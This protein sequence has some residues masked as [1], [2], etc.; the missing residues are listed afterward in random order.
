FMV[1]RTS[2][3]QANTMTENDTDRMS[4]ITTT[5]ILSSTPTETA[6]ISAVLPSDDNSN[7]QDN[8]TNWKVNDVY[9]DGPDGGYGWWVILGAFLG[10]FTSFGTASSCFAGTIME[11]FVDLMG[12]VFQIVAARYGVRTVLILGSFL[13]VLGLELAGF[14]TKVTIIIY[15]ICISHKVFYS[16]QVHLL[17]MCIVIN[18]CSSNIDV[19]CLKKAAMSVPAQWFNRRRGVGLGIVSSGSGFG[20]LILPFIMTGINDKLGAS[21]TYRIM[22]FVCL[23]MNVVT[24]LL[25]KEKYPRHKKQKVNTGNKE[26]GEE[27]QQ[28]SESRHPTL[29]ETFNFSVLKDVN[30]LLWVIGSVIALMG[31]FIP[32]FFVPSYAR[33]IGLSSS[34]GTAIIA[35]MSA[36]N[37]IG[38]VVIGYIGDHIGRLNANILFT[39][40]SGLSA[41][42][43]WIFAYSYGTL[44]AF[45]VV[46]G[47][48]CSS[49]VALLS[50]ITATIL[51]IERF[52]TGL[53]IL[54]LSN[55]ISVFSPTIVSAIEIRVSSEPYLVYKLSCGV[56][57]IVGGLFLILLKVRMTHSLLVKI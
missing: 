17:Y 18:N 23:A 34:D 19:I 32:F 45:A 9:D 24:C 57:Y 56:F 35:V 47:L 22:G 44:M 49:Y 13:G 52:P 27:E 54:L 33:Y 48:V 12:P 6:T 1:T 21:W 3:I 29:R 55:M 38:R 20:G 51:G 50:P 53:S 40:L 16:D 37:C 5:S 15:G 41:I 25:V 30:Y 7:I 46:F 28:D 36:G 39:M 14:T 43:I 42:T 11:L 4:S 10:Q 31:F 26:K 8:K 2:I